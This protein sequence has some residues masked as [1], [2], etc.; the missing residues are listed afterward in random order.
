M[1]LQILT[2]KIIKKNKLQTIYFKINN[3]INLIFHVLIIIINLIILINLIMLFIWNHLL[4]VLNKL[5]VKI[6]SVT[7]FKLLNNL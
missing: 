3:N 1:I 7:I 2:N 5:L 4:Y 6:S